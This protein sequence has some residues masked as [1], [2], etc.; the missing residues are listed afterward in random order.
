MRGGD[1][2]HHPEGC[3]PDTL[4]NT[5]GTR[6]EAEHTLGEDGIGHEAPAGEKARKITEPPIVKQARD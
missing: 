1:Q 3:H 6:L 5:Q 2:E 4:K